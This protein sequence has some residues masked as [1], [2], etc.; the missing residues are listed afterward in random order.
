MIKDRCGKSIVEPKFS[1]SIEGYV[2]LEPFLT[3][4]TNEVLIKAFVRNYGIDRSISIEVE[5]CGNTVDRRRIT[6]A[7]GERYDLELYSRTKDECNVKLVVDGKT[8]DVQRVEVL[9]PNDIDIPTAIV[10][11]FHHHQPPNYGPD[12]RYRA[13][14]PFKYIWSPLLFP[15]GLGPYHYQAVLLK[16]L[17]ENVKIAYNISPSLIKQW[18]DLIENGIR[19]SFNE[20]LEP[21]SD[22]AKTVKESVDL[23]RE[24]ADIGIIEVLTSIYAH[25]IAGYVV[26]VLGLEDVIYRELEYG[27]NI[28]KEF[29]GRNPRGL[30]LPEMSFSMKLIHI[31]SS[32][33]LEYTFLDERYHL[34]NAQ[35]DVSDHYEPY[36][37]Q[38]PVTGETITVFFRDTELSNDIGFNNNY[39]SDI[40]AIKGAHEFTLK[41]ITKAI[42]NK[43]RS[44]TIALDGENW[45]IFSENPPATAIFLETLLGLL[46][47]A[48]SIGLIK[49]SHPSKV[50]N[51]IPPTRKLRF[52][53]STTWLGSYRKWRGEIEEHE[54]FW[55]LVEKRVAKYKRYVFDHGF[56]E[57]AKKAEWALWHII[58]SDYWW[59]EFWDE[60]A[61][62]AWINEFDRYIT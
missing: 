53:P 27:Y 60:E 57:V 36:I 58:D 37:V 20:I 24:L 35:G 46:K 8:L 45:M 12:L 56:N 42:K 62:M 47:R 21:S 44:L 49:L 59:A 15:Y 11:V 16:R 38:D 48:N 7:F 1:D 3:E 13:L 50:I 40:H 55:Q 18:F 39:C 29:T 6:L 30:W 17:G 5:M 4:A 51:E 19:T 31:I 28:T 10:L 33:S 34:M 22:L 9:S 26:D 52:I 23:Y 25:T 54:K 14:W 61:I 2:I 43:A 32:L 41:L